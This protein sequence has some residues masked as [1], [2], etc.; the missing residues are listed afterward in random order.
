[1][2]KHVLAVVVLGLLAL[3]MARMPAA[4][5]A[6]VAALRTA[7]ILGAPITEAPDA[8][9]LGESLLDGPSV[10]P[11]DGGG[12]ILW[13]SGLRL[14]TPQHPTEDLEVHG[15]ARRSLIAGLRALAA[16]RGQTLQVEGEL[17]P[18]Q[19]GMNVLVTLDEAG[20]ALEAVSSDGSVLAGA[21]PGW[22]P[23]ERMALFPPF[24]AIALA[25]LLRR[26]ILS[27]FA[28]VW[29]AAWV[30]RYAGGTEGALRA[31]AR[32]LPDVATELLWPQLVDPMRLSI[33]GFVFAMLA[34]IGVMTRSGGIRGLMDLVA[35]L[36][37]N[38]RRTQIATWLMGLVVFFDDYA[39]CI[40][41]G[42]TMRP[43]TDRFRVSR[44]KLSYLVDSTA[45][46]VAGISIFS[47]WIAFEVS[48]FSAQLPAAGLA[49][50]EGYAVFVQTLPFRFYCIL[51]IFF[52]GLLALSGRD[53]GP[54]LTAERRA[55]RTGAV[56]RE[57][58]RPMVSHDAAHL[59]PSAG[60]VPR[61]RSAIV[62]LLVFIGLTLFEIARVGF[63]AVRAQD[64]EFGWSALWT[65]R[66][67][68][69]L[70]GEGDSTSALLWGSSAGL[71][72]AALLAFA[73]G[74]RLEILRAAWATLRSMGVAV[75]ILYLAWMIGLAC[76]RM[77]TAP[78]L[79]ALVGEN[80]PPALLPAILFGM[81]AIVAFATGSSWSTMSILLPLVVGLSF[82]MGEA[83]DLGG[84]LLMVMSIGAVL[85]GSIFGDHC[86]PISDTTVLSSTAS[87]AD[88]IDH[89]RTQM[90]YA[91]L[92]MIVALS[93][94]YIPCAFSG[95]HPFLSLL[96]G[97][98]LLT[99]VVFLLGKRSEDP[100]PSGA[101]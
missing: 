66:G 80:L 49:P 79:T 47:T 87:A 88:H 97:A 42:A 74:L 67:I 14:A 28:G 83:S 84:T 90:P 11:G 59:E 61:A 101:G 58:G 68:T 64:P 33:M 89:V 73:A 43:L 7:E 52:A 53:F 40:L 56:V 10:R 17:W 36:A 9:S 35:R 82:S 6:R 75:A 4:D 27:L 55:R 34:M 32:S 45:A 24:F 93:V 37:S 19:G 78:Y 98:A 77:G 20:F 13:I 76:D 26:P 39:N 21:L 70:L 41:V 3:G 50:E 29:C 25:V 81:S 65:V 22:R 100:D 72:A 1:M 30:L 5:P 91:A 8:P 94:G 48:T 54:M 95:A 23:P 31:V 12:L 85:E 44:E 2:R 92:V 51:T 69:A 57:G 99:A 46:P 63:S 16:E 71:A 62:P 86:S 38:A 15:L 60:V 96:G 18:S